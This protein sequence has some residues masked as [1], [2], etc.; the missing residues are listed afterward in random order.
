MSSKLASTL[1]FCAV[2]GSFFT[3][4]HSSTIFEASVSRSAICKHSVVRFLALSSN[5]P[6]HRFRGREHDDGMMLLQAGIKDGARLS[7][8]ETTAYREHQ[9]QA[10]A[11]QEQEAMTQREQ[12]QAVQQVK[13]LP[14]MFSCLCRILIRQSTCVRLAASVRLYYG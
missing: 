4:K 6:C 8:A 13:L 5:T 7:I 14:V 3:H 9:A 2:G 11:C 1:Q 10:Q 12:A